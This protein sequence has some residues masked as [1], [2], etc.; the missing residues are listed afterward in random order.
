MGK[1]QK[2]TYQKTLSVKNPLRY[3][4][5]LNINLLPLMRCRLPRAL[6]SVCRGVPKPVEI[7][8]CDHTPMPPSVTH[9]ASL[10]HKTG[11]VCRVYIWI[12]RALTSKRT[13]RPY[14]TNIKRI[15]NFEDIDLLIKLIKNISALH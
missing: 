2:I 8:K 5:R 3:V 11:P 4:N 13:R 6:R 10:K 15:P 7:E 12:R 14:S 9:I 1:A